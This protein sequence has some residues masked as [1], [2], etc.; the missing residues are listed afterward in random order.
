[1]IRYGTAQPSP[2]QLCNETPNVSLEHMLVTESSK[3]IVSIVLNAVS[4]E[5][6]EWGMLMHSHTTTNSTYLF[7]AFWQVHAFMFVVDSCG[8]QRMSEAKTCLD[9]LLAHNKAKGKPLLV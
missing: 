6:C 7:C 8:V 9:S 1:M 4:G 3:V 2:F 5:C